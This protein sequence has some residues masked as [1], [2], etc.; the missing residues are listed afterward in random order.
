MNAI[1]GAMRQRVSLQSPVETPDDIG[2]VI[3]SF[4]TVATVFGALGATGGEELPTDERKGQRLAF[5]LTIRWRGDVKAEWRALV[6]ARI[7]DVKTASDL[8]GRQRFLILSLEEV[9]P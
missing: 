8:D 3:R 5:R 1:I 6:G 9:T 7:F 2:G 4:S